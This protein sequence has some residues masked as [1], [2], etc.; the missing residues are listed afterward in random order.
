MS[1]AQA[2]MS[3]QTNI[4]HRTNIDQKAYRLSWSTLVYVG[5]RSDFH[6]F[7]RAPAHCRS[8]L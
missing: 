4:D 8:A 1:V 6:L 2:L 7:R 3:A 5:R